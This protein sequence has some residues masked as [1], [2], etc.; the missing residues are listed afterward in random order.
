VDSSIFPLIPTGNPYIPV[1]MVAERAAD[2]ILQKNVQKTQNSDY[3]GILKN[4]ERNSVE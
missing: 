4:L 1:I 2:F 3:N